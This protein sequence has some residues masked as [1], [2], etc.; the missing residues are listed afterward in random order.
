MATDKDKK[1]PTAAQCITSVDTQNKRVIVT[2]PEGHTDPLPDTLH[3]VG[4]TATLIEP[5]MYQFPEETA[6]PVEPQCYYW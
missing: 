5:G 4:E 6:L 3:C 2:A 1:K